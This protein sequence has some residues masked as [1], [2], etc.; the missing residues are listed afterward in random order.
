MTRI[1]HSADAA[2][3]EHVGNI[4]KMRNLAGLSANFGRVTD[5][6]LNSALEVID[7]KEL[8]RP[9]GLEPATSWFVGGKR[10]VEN[11]TNLPRGSKI[12]P[13]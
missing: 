6:A 9:A 8:V 3:R 12:L 2:P 1:V 10:S 7:P 4:L 5:R 13:P 11:C